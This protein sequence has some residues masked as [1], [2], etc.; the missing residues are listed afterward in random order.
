MDE[1]LRPNPREREAGL[2]LMEVIVGLFLVLIL[3]SIL[4]YLIRLGFAMYQLNATTSEVAQKLE[5]GRNLAMSKN[6]TVRVIFEYKYGKFGVDTNGNAR[7]DSAEADELPE[8]VS[9]SEDAVVIFT[10]T[11]KLSEGSKEPQIVVSNSKDSRS[12]KVSSLGAIEID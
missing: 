6:Q 2:G 7:L 12:V 4:L 11:G 1:S 8:G 9:L 5:K 3:G 10:R